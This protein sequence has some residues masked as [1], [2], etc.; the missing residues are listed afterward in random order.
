MLTRLIAEGARELELELLLP[1]EQLAV[2]IDALGDGI[3]RQKLADPD[4]VPDELFGNALS[5]LLAG[6]ARP[7]PR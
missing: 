5:L 4:A 3:A 7:A 6:A 1:A 2:A